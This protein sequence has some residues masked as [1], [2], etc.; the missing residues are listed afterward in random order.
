LT[1]RERPVNT[2][3][4]CTEHPCPLAVLAKALHGNAF[5]MTSVS[6]GRVDAP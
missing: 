4:V 3:L 5:K 6:T 2:G 1:T